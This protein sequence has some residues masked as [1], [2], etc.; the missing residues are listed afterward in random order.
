MDCK[1][2]EVEQGSDEWLDL[3]RGR[4]T[5]S[6]LKRVMSKPSTKGYQELQRLIAQELNGYEPVEEDAPWFA[7]G[8]EQEP[9]ALALYSWQ[10]R[11]RSTTCRQ[12]T[13]TKYRAPWG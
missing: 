4:I 8:K 13:A 12:R 9:R 5:A 7:H 6:R 1:I 3:R 10:I 11:I 2:I